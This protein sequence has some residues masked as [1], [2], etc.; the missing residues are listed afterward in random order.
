MSYITIADIEDELLK[1]LMQQSD[2]DS[3]DEE[4]N[5]L[6]TDLGVTVDA[7]NTTPL[8]VRVKNFAIAKACERRANMKTGFNPRSH[9]G[10]TGEDAYETKRK[11]YAQQAD[12]LSTTITPYMLTGK[13]PTVGKDNV[14]LYHM[15]LNRG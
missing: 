8:N 2:F 3:A 5:Q 6:A 14:G 11:T 12:K 7:I 4:V 1:P 10:G 13:Y 15:T 9:Q